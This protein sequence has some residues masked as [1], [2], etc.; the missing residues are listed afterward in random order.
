MTTTDTGSLGSHSHADQPNWR[1]GETIDDYLGNCREGPEQFSERRFAKL[2][3]LSRAKLWRAKQV[4]SLPKDLFEILVEMPDPP[5]VRELANVARALRGQHSPGV[6]RCRNCGEIQ[7]VR[8]GWRPATEK[9][10]N[11][12]LKANQAP[13]TDQ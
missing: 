11:D 2:S 8:G 9:V 4:A 1:P 13:A 7:R 3:G 6:E 12:W 5:S 10:V